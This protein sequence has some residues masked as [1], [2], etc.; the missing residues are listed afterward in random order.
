MKPPLLDKE[1]IEKRIECYSE[2]Y[3]IEIVTPMFGG[4]VTAGVVD[5]T[6]PIRATAIRGH[7]RFWWRMLYGKDKQA[8]ELFN[9]E[10]DIWGDTKKKSKVEILIKAV[11]NYKE[12]Q[13]NLTDDPVNQNNE[14]YKKKNSKGKLVDAEGK[15]GFENDSPELYILFSTITNDK[16]IN[17]YLLKEGFKFI[18]RLSFSNS[19][20]DD[21]KEV[22]R[23]AMRA[24]VCF[25][26]IGSRTRKGCG[27][28]KFVSN[29][30]DKD[31]VKKIIEKSQHKKEIIDLLERINC[32]GFCGNATVDSSKY[33]QPAKICAWSRSIEIY[34]EFRQG[35]CFARTK[36]Y[37]RSHWSEADS[38]RELSNCAL[39]KHK[40]PLKETKDLIPCF[41]RSIM[42]LPIIIHF[43]DS[44]QSSPIPNKEPMDFTITP[45]YENKNYERMASPIITKPIFIEGK[46]YPFV[47]ILPYQH[48]LDM[49]INV[50]GKGIEKSIEKSYGKESIHSEKLK[51]LKPL[52]NQENAIAAFILYINQKNYHLLKQ[53]ENKK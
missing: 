2:E 22:V 28:L 40:D 41:P 50:K 33:P 20:S 16:K 34:K 38:I 25:G 32:Q 6:M 35:A 4:G 52:K 42:G 17:K 15:F 12:Y 48:A 51:K 14:R 23:D 37:G 31:F 30:N 18:L 27:A 10:S 46:W 7:L 9:A 36:E 49:E 24:W 8:D 26:G 44:P 11:D 3:Q 29:E 47:L 13:R 21:N 53:K 19:L 5:E 39:P 1:K 45:K 43:K